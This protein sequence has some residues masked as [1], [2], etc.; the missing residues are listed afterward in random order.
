ML[1][2]RAGWR[3]ELVASLHDRGNSIPGMISNPPGYH[4]WV[5]SVP[6][7]IR[8]D[9][10]WKTPA[11]R[12]ALMLGDQARTDLETVR[13]DR[14]TR[15]IADQ[16]QRCVSSISANLAEGYSRTTGPERARF[17]EYALGSGREARDWYYKMR[18]TLGANV[19]A[20]RLS[21]V[22]RIVRILTAVVPRERATA[23]TRARATAR[24]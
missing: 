19:V 8:D 12:L 22:T 6:A 2:L 16:L 17:Y 5:L 21:L 7:E 1:R 24:R 20:E 3:A 15:A 18:H 13:A 23:L 11:Y 14:G 10:L 4:E 9:P